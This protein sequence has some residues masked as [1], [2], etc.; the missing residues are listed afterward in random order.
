MKNKKNLLIIVGIVIIAGISTSL[1]L[2]G[3]N[4][5]TNAEKM[6]NISE[7]EVNE[8]LKSLTEFS[9][10]QIE[11]LSKKEKEQF[12]TGD[13]YEA[14]VGTYKI[15]NDNK[16]YPEDQ[17]PTLEKQLKDYAEKADYKVIIDTINEKRR[18][19]K[20][21]E[22]YNLN[23]ASIFH[24]AEIMMALKNYDYIKQGEVARSMLNP[25]MM[26]SG[27]L[28][29]EEKSRRGVITDKDSLS[30]IF[31][32][33]VKIKEHEIIFDEPDDGIIKRIYNLCIGATCVHKITFEIEKNE[34][35]AYIVEYSNKTLEFYGI[36][37]PDGIE[38]YYQPISFWE[39]IDDDT[40]KHFELE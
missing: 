18:A 5:N 13:G 26:V 39:K 19:Y 24:D 10:E 3:K 20:F 4:K 27:T 37:A 30:P 14:Y 15:E 29:L 7:K 6:D 23:I 40:M 32:G 12:L 31:D 8:T 16:E 1:Y 35:I 34:L 11:S 38:T 33:S 17:S 2:V 9:D 28:M 21:T 36:Y 25:E 22:N